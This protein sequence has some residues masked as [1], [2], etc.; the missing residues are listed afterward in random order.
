MPSLPEFVGG[1]SGAGLSDTIV[2][3][4]SLRRAVRNRYYVRLRTLPPPRGGVQEAGAAAAV[5]RTAP[6]QR[7]SAHGLPYSDAH[8]RWNDALGRQGYRTRGR[9]PLLR[10][11]PRRRD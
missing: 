2:L 8:G 1:S 7:R 3:D 9:R 5:E 11:D 6:R 4:A 10:S